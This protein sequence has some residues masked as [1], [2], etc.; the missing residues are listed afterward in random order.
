MEKEIFTTRA[1]SKASI[2]KAKCEKNNFL[3]ISPFKFS[4]L[5]Y[6]IF[7]ADDG[8]LDQYINT[9]EKHGQPTRRLDGLYIF[10]S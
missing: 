1:H 9:C 5:C 3:R 10:S 2:S 8:S 6:Q 4:S 7:A